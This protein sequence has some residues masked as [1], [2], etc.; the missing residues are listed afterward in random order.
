VQGE[1]GERAND[2]EQCVPTIAGN[3][4]GKRIYCLEEK[5]GEE[6]VHTDPEQERNVLFDGIER[7]SD[8]RGPALCGHGDILVSLSCVEDSSRLSHSQGRIIDDPLPPTRGIRGMAACG[9]A[10][11]RADGDLSEE[12]S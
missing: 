11:Y 8:N 3:V 7:G 10:S 2:P 12:N 5:N 9:P 6:S 4:P 1:K